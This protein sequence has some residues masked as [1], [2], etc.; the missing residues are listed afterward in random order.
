MVPITE[1]P[2]IEPLLTLKDI[3]ARLGLPAFKVTRAAKL[4]LF[5]TYALFNQRKLARLSEVIAAIE[6]SRTGGQS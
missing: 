5:P 4:G 6:S 1:I 3:A 2:K